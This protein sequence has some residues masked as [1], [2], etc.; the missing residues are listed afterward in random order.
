MKPPKKVRKATMSPS[1]PVPLS[2]ARSPGVLVA[3]N[4][5][6]I[7]HQVNGVCLQSEM[8][9]PSASADGTL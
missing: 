3:G 7:I 2:R 4:P 8:D 1:E 5:A 6:E 9:G